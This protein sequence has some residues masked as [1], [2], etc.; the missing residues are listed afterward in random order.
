[1]TGWRIGYILSENE[2]AMTHITKMQYYVTACSNDAMQ[3][4]VLE[5]MEKAPDYPAQMCQEFKARRD[6]SV[7]D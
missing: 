6:Q 1:M 4:A 3:Y 5:A 2:E 7:I